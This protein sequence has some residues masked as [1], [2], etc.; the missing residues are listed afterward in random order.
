M[1][2]RA[3]TTRHDR[4]MLLLVRYARSNGVLARFEPKDMGSRVPDGEFIF[5][6]KVVTVDMT[7]VHSLAPSHLRSSRRPGKAI[8]RRG[9]SKHLK[10]DTDAEAIGASFAALVVD[11]FGSLHEDFT[12][13]VDEIEETGLRTFAWVGWGGTL[14]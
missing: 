1:R 12:K 3:V 7:G 5:P 6:R 4:S 13:L 14:I 10:Y 8:E 9:R 11:S 2:R